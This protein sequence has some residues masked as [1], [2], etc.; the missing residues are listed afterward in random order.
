MIRAL[1][2]MIHEAKAAGTKITICGEMASDHYAIPLLVGL[3]YSSLSVNAAAI[4][5]LKKIVRN[6]N[7]EEC[8]VLVQQCL[9]MTTEDEIKNNIQKFYNDRFTEDVDEVFSSSQQ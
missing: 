8:R 4:P 7:F 2:F 6:L 3:G 1:E 9:K 5:Y